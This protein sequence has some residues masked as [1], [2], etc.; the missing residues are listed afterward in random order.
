[1]RLY[2]PAWRDRYVEEFEAL[3]AAGPGGIGTALNVVWA[4]LCERVSP[5]KGDA[6]GERLRLKRFDSWSIRAPW[7][8]YGLAPVFLLGLAYFTACFVL[9]SGWRIFLAGQN[10]PF[11][12]VYGLPEYYFGIGRLLYETAPVLVGWFV[13]IVAALRTPPD[14]VAGCGTGP[15]RLDRRNGAGAR[16]PA[17]LSQIRAR[18]HELLAGALRIRCGDSAGHSAPMG[19]FADEKIPLCCC[20]IAA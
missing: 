8:I 7:A 10:S 18:E 5:T 16:K 12:P 15:A 3:L 9:W 1:V 19:S 6:M 2:P 14:A 11:V 20:L 17:R 13:G 4:A